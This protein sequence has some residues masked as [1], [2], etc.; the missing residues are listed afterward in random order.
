MT[1]YRI[2]SRVIQDGIDQGIFKVRPGFGH[3]AM[4]YLTWTI[5]HGIA[6]IKS[7][8]VSNLGLEFPSNHDMV[9][10]FLINNL[11]GLPNA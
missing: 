3:Q 7:S 11:K 5:I 2:A 9:L 1:A 6:S 4:F 10:T 8:L